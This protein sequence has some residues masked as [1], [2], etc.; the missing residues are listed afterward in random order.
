M[1]AAIEINNAATVLM[2]Y[3]VNWFAISGMQSVA[4]VLEYKVFSAPS[5]R[6]LLIAMVGIRHYNLVINVAISGGA[7]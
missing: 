6:L 4:Y 3:G 1:H 2:V 7:C 5:Y